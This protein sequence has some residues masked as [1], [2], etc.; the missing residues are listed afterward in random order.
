MCQ[1]FTACCV[2]HMAPPLEPPW[3]RLRLVS[4]V[5]PRQ[6]EMT[7]KVCDKW[8]TG[9]FYVGSGWFR[10]FKD[11]VFLFSVGSRHALQLDFIARLS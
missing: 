2:D 7:R 8:N 3:I 6:Q 1:L 4:G 10:H 9:L 11:N 5:L